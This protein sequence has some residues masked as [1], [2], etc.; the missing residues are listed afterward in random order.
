MRRDARENLESFILEDGTGY[1]F[2]PSSPEIFLHVVGCLAAQGDGKAFPEPPETWKAVAR[3]RNREAALN[4]VLAGGSFVLCPY[5]REA[6]AESGQLR[7][8]SLISGH[9]LGEG[10]LPDLSE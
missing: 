4:Q 9:E 8:R 1:W 3:A 7:P 6:L 10:E 2:D 5:E